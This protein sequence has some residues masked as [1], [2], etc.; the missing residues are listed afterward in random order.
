M[1]IRKADEKDINSILNMAVML[2]KQHE[3]YSTYYKLRHSFR[4]L[5][6]QYYISLLNDVSVHFIVALINEEIVGYAYASI[7]K[8]GPYYQETMFGSLGEVFV[9]EEHRKKGIADKLIQEILR[10]FRQHNVHYSELEV[11]SLNALALKKWQQKGYV[12]FIEKM[13]LKLD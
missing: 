6:N 9:S 8:R 2:H 4:S 5:I 12:K 7:G 3:T 13:L 10:W 1:F 11:D